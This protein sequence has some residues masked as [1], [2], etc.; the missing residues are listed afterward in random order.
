MR[1]ACVVTTRFPMI[2]RQKALQYGEHT[3]AASVS[4]T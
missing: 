4:H 1:I 2:A 3:I